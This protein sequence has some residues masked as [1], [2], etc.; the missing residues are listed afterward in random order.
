MN[1][2]G[3]S[4]IESS[5]MVKQITEP[6]RKAKSKRIQ[7][8]FN[9]RY[10]FR[11]RTIPLKKVFFFNHSFIGHPDII[12]GIIKVLDKDKGGCKDV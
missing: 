6:K 2:N 12:K 10:G 3:F 7:K 9:K 1:W 4:L 5:S 11:T 8:K